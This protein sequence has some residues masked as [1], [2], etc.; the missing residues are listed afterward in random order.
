MYESVCAEEVWINDKFPLGLS[1]YRLG[2]A[3]NYHAADQSVSNRN[4]VDRRSLR[5]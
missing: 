2:Y 3:V 1:D 4:E 5:S